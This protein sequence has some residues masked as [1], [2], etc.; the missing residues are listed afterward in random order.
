M[1]STSCGR[2][3]SDSKYTRNLSNILHECSPFKID[4]IRPFIRS[5]YVAQKSFSVNIARFR[6]IMDPENAIWTVKN[7]E[8]YVDWIVKTTCAIAGCFA[9]SYL[10]S[11]LPVCRLSV[12]FCELILPRIIYLIIQEYESSIDTMC[13]CFNRFFRYCFINARK[14]WRT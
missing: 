4:Y 1:L 13:D 10:E 8:N 9:D 14:H 5:R 6:T 2:K 7:D 3:L 12:E 11:F